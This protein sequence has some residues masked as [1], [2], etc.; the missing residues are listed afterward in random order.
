MKN[1]I[2]LKL[3]FLLSLLI[4]T[5]VFSQK[6]IEEIDS[7]YFEVV[8][9]KK[10][11][12][13]VKITNSKT[14]EIFVMNSKYTG[15]GAYK[16]ITNCDSLNSSSYSI[17]INI[18]SDHYSKKTMTRIKAGT[19]KRVRFRLSS[20]YFG[21]NKCDSSKSA[22]TYLKVFIY[23]INEEQDKKKIGYIETIGYVMSKEKIIVKVEHYHSG[24]KKKKH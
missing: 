19:S 6:E 12:L 10:R 23:V 3:T 14:S 11:G 9:S 18:P 24:D 16:Y 15:Q 5:A 1:L 20:D 22:Y 13:K 8:K 2:T 17:P 7:V 21:V 4:S